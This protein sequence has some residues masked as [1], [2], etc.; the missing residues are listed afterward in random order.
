MSDPILIFHRARAAGIRFQQGDDGRWIAV[1][2]PEL[3]EKWRPAFADLW[4]DVQKSLRPPLANDCRAA[5]PVIRQDP[6]AWRTAGQAIRR[7]RKPAEPITPAG[8]AY[9]TRRPQNGAEGPKSG[10]AA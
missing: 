6:E 2:S 5:A 7:A 3:W 8:A 9:P 4:P 10:R 1:C